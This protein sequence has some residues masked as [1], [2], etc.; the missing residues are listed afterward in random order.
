MRK[1]KHKLGRPSL[2]LCLFSEIEM[3]AMVEQISP[4][5]PIDL[6]IADPIRLH[7][8]LEIGQSLRGKEGREHRRRFAQRRP[9]NKLII[10][11]PLTLLI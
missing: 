6:F 8:Q 9:K 4:L 10:R 5:K 11:K 3:S 7:W 1:Q 2:Q